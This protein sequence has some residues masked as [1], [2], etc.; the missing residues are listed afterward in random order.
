MICPTPFSQE[1]CNGVTSSASLLLLRSLCLC[2]STQAITTINMSTVNPVKEIPIIVPCAKQECSCEEKGPEIAVVV[3]EAVM[4]RT[5]VIADIEKVLFTVEFAVNEMELLIA[6]VT[7][8][9]VGLIRTAEVVRVLRIVLLEIDV[10]NP[11]Q[12]SIRKVP[13]S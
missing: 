2:H 12:E 9:P 7:D 11:R 3:E 8:A 6:E 4:P 10:D 13:D 5:A 1:E